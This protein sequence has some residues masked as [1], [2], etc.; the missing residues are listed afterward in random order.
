MRY[1]AYDL[2]LLM[3][4]KLALYYGEKHPWLELKDPTVLKEEVQEGM[5]KAISLLEST[6][7]GDFYNQ[8][9]DKID[10]IEEITMILARNLTDKSFKALE[11]YIIHSQDQSGRE[12]NHFKELTAEELKKI[13]EE[14]L[15][16]AQQKAIKEF[17]EKR[18]C[19]K[20]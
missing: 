2:C 18:R 14:E 8:Y 15:T 16:P 20:C 7:Q 4:E 12:L 13:Y 6:K 5:I 9:S 11:Q 10:D 3:S 17:A 19:V 1:Y